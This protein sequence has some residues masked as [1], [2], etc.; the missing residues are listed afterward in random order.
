MTLMTCLDLILC[1]FKKSGRHN[2]WSNK[3]KNFVTYIKLTLFLDVLNLPIIQSNCFV[4][5]ADSFEKCAL[6]FLNLPIFLPSPLTNE[7][8]N[9][10]LLTE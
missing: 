10:F 9:E 6:D 1:L 5:L 3:K 7:S 8:F 2:S 4:S